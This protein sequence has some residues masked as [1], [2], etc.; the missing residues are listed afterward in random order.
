MSKRRAA[1]TLP[2]LPSVEELSVEELHSADID[3]SGEAVPADNAELIAPQPPTADPEPPCMVSIEAPVRPILPGYRTR[4]V[5]IQSLT[6][7][8]SEGL[9][10]LQAGLAET[11]LANGRLV[12]SK[13]DAVRW[14][15]EQI[16]CGQ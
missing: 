14:L 4:H 15:L 10:R 11:R 9:T 6:A 2:N 1:K 12:Q 8:Q 7:L 3:E 16:A 13:A 5:Q